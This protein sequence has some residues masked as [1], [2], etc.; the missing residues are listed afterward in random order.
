MFAALLLMLLS[1]AALLYLMRHGEA[2]LL[3]RQAVPHSELGAVREEEPMEGFAGVRRHYALTLPKR[4][5]AGLQLAFFVRHQYAEVLIDGQRRFAVQPEGQTLKTPGNYWAM[6]SLRGRDAGK[7]AEIILT[8]VYR[9]STEP[10]FL[11]TPKEFAF[12]EQL[13]SDLLL[14]ILGLMAILT[15]F[16]LVLLVLTVPFERR[17]KRALTY[18]SLLSFSGG[19]WKLLGLPTAY[20]VLD[21]WGDRFY[22]YA[23]APYLAGMIAYLFMP[24]FAMQFL[25]NLREGGEAPAEQIGAL[26]AALTA[27]V[28]FVLQMLGVAE[29]HDYL[30]MVSVLNALLMVLSLADM[31]RSRSTRHR[32]WLFSFPISIA[33]DLTIAW[34]THSSRC[35]IAL[36]LCILINALAHGVVFVRTATRAEADAQRMRLMTLAGQIQPHFIQNALTS[37]YYLC[38]SDPQKAMQMIRAFSTY[39]ENDFQAA[40]NDAPIPFERELEHTRAYLAVEQL[41]FEG[42]LFVQIDTASTMFRLPPLTLQPIVE[43]AVKR[44]LGKGVS[45]EHITIRAKER[46]DGCELTV[47]DDAP[48]S[49]GDALQIVDA[50]L[51]T[52]SG[53][54]LRIEPLADGTR[55]TVWIPKAAEEKKPFLLP[56]RGFFLRN[57]G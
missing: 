38:D 9:S 8:P 21:W 40:T 33:V 29:L 49:D 3:V 4:V 44:G 26:V 47:E 11:L 13:R 23:T 46:D 28:L 18:L 37:A 24:A 31:L 5:D 53:G 55:V 22:G 39:L 48:P 12:K 43:D 54:E 34:V 6:I 27:V 32:L 15:G 30:N 51:R 10:R 16:L 52:L 17:R 7:R 36:L 2:K 20:L 42:E 14:I 25:N 56:E 35:A 57:P 19:V 45:P 1:G 41:R 50:R